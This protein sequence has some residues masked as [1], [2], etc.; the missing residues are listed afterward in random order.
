MKTLSHRSMQTQSRDVSQ[1]SVCSLTPP[2]HQDR[3]DSFEFEFDFDCVSIR[4]ALIPETQRILLVTAQ[5]NHGQ[6]K[7]NHHSV[8]LRLV[9]VTSNVIDFMKIHQ[10]TVD[11]FPHF[12]KDRKIV[13]FCV[14]KL[15]MKSK[16]KNRVL[17]AQ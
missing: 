17:C 16:V 4:I 7:R 14:N 11:N 5:T 15:L 8:R 2:V 10:K 1:F 12:V 6:M 13:K 3:A 9:A